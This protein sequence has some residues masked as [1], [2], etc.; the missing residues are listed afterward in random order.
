M[1]YTLSNDYFNDFYCY[2]DNALPPRAYFIPFANLAACKK[3]DYLSERYSSSMVKVLNGNW[4]FAFYGKISDMPLEMDTESMKFDSVKVP[5]CWQFQGYE[6]PFYINTRYMFDLKTMPLVPADK[7]YFGKNCRTQN[8]EKG[9]DVF[10]SVGVYR[11]TFS[12]KKTSRNIVT[13]LGVSSCLQLYVNGF[14][15]GYGEGSHN[16]HEFD[17]TEYLFDDDKA[18]E[19]VVLVYKWCNGTYLECQDMFRNNGIFRDVYITSLQENYIWDYKLTTI[20][21]EKD[22]YGLRVEASSVKEPDTQTVCTLCYGEEELESKTGNQVEFTLQSPELWSAEIPNLYT[23]YIQLVKNGKVVHCIRQEVGIKNIEIDGNV[24]YFNDKAIKLKGVNHHDTHESNGYV[25]TVEELKKDIDLMKKLNVNAVRTSHYPPDPILLKIANYEGIY[26]IDEADIETHG[27]Y[28]VNKTIALPNRISNNLKWQNHF[29]DRVFRMYMRDRNNVCVTMWSLGNE[30]GGWKNQD[31]CYEKLKKLDPDTPIHYEAVCRTPRFNYDVVSQMYASTEFYEKYVENK[32]PKK[33]YRAPYFQCEFAHAMGVGPGSLEKYWELMN[34]S[35]SALGG[36]IWEWADH[37]VKKSK[38]YLYGGDHGEYAHD[39]NFCVDGLVY[40]DRSLSVSALNMQAVFRP[41]KASYISNNKYL[42]RNYNRFLSTSYL[43]IKWQFL[44]SGEIVEEG[45]LEKDIPP[46][47]DGE[48]VINHPPI[49]TARECFINFIYIDKRTGEFVAKEQITLSQFIKVPSHPKGA[50]IVSVEENDRL[51][52]FTDRAKIVFNIKTGKIASYT[53]D[54]RDFFHYGEDSQILTPTIYRAP[55][56][57]YMYK[58]KG[59]KAL[60]F[61][62]LTSKLKSFEY[63]KTNGGLFVRTQENLMHGSKVRFNV[64]MEYNVYCNGEIDVTATLHKPNGYDIPK[65]GLT[66]DI[67]CEFERVEYY[68]MGEKESYSDMNEHALMGIYSMGIDDMFE[69]Y[70]K[71]QDN[72]NRSC[73]RWA[74]LLDS[75]GEGLEFMGNATEFNFNA[76]RYDDK[77]IAQSKHAFELKPLAKN[78]VRIDG[79][80]RGVGSNSCGPDTRAEFRHTSKEDIS[81]SFRIKAIVEDTSDK[82]EI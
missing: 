57:N 51:K 7:G 59:W 65:F 55:I 3:T 31:C 1:K 72:G 26:M 63:E 28:G 11:K 46:M 49:D 32:A 56:D 71:P 69:K 74:R 34:A 15:V 2:E 14:Y 22:K 13:F 36:C 76:N 64:T 70:I 62:C 20:R 44:Y 12:I 33:F 82:K 50:Q 23:L 53:I 42:F 52:V 19:I 54:D 29:W 45:V 67:P 39:S 81:Y 37:A 79:F 9:A 17:I 21:E 6:F 43:E 75:N 38:G 47:C 61:D 80:V 24:F 35:P 58:I 30:S 78:V 16:T 4:D 40:P 8:G 41:V 10:N 73:V 25:M 27:C 48:A 66:I 68:G 77:T 5:G 60:G 18:N